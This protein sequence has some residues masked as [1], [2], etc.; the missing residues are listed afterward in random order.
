MI[1]GLTGHTGHN[2]WETMWGSYIALMFNSRD[3]FEVTEVFGRSHAGRIPH[4]RMSRVAKNV[5]EDGFMC[6]VRE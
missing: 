1:V 3:I 5:W 6:M 2:K 4:Y